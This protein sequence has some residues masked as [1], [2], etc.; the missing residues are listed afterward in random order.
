[1]DTAKTFDSPKGFF[2]RASSP[3]VEGEL[4]ILILGGRKGAGIVAFESASG[5]VRWKSTDDEA[6][7]AS[8]VG[9]TIRGVRV[10]LALNREA[11][12]ALRPA[13]GQVLFRYPWR[14]SMHASVS[15]ATPLVIGDLIFLSAS[16]GAGATL[17]RFGETAPTVV[18]SLA[19][20]LSNHYA[21][22]VHHR[23]FLY[24]WHGR[25]EQGCEL[26]CIELE[27][28]KVRWREPGLKA[29]SV[30]IA[31]EELLVLTEKGL[32]LRAPASPEAFKPTE[33]CQALPFDCRAFPAISN[34]RLFT[35]S[36]SELFCLDLTKGP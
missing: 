35:R 28:G 4:V 1:V 26:R 6:S 34:G 7:Y 19:D 29:G 33:R 30:T 14:P 18:W 15:A 5:K 12:V 8:T 22:S 13:D 27:T 31:G 23:G 11:L 20:A 32:L 10:V 17:L 2:G 25:Q 9:A 24:G 3:L 16:Y 21:T 36:K